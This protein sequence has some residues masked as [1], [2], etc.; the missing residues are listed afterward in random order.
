MVHRLIRKHGVE[1][2]TIVL[3]TIAESE[4][5]EGELIADVISAIS[6]L[7]HAHP[8]WVALGMQWLEAFDQIR[9]AHIPVT[10][11]AANVQLLRVGIATLIAVDLE[12]LLGPSKLPKS[13]K[14]LRIKREPKPP[15]SATRIPEI[16][17]AIALERTIGAEGATPSN[18]QFRQAR[19]RFNVDQIRA[20]RAIRVARIYA[21]RPEIYRAVSWWT[22]VELSSPKMSQSVR[23][24][25][26][27]K[28]MAGQSIN[29]H[30]IRRGRG[31]LNPGKSKRADQPAVRMAA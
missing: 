30:Q 8:R 21:A 27:S 2:A 22:L 19:A 18:T 13:P 23:Q 20:S 28:I 9:L 1:H 5:N 12:R 7:I 29:A 11:K 26:E 17:R 24:A 3:R 4:G 6:D 14:P 25:F 31:E 16:E 15:R 10:P